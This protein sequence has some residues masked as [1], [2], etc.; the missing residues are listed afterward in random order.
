MHI[1]CA[2]EGVAGACG[3]AVYA[4]GFDEVE[5]LMGRHVVDVVRVPELGVIVHMP[6][7]H[8]VAG[9]MRVP[10]GVLAVLEQEELPVLVGL[11]RHRLV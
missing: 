10:A 4:V 5:I 11:D 2:R 7:Q 1:A 3:G 9:Q 6:H 8:A